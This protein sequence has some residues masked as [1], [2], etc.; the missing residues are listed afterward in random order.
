MADY[1]QICELYYVYRKPGTGTFMHYMVGGITEEHCKKDMQD[2]KALGIDAFA[3]NFNQ[4]ADWSRQTVDHL[5]NSADSYQFKLFFSFDMASGYFTDPSQYAQY[6]SQYMSRNAY[7]KIRGKPLVTTFG[8]GD[9][10]DRAW[11]NFKASLDA[12]IIL[13]LGLHSTAA[14]SSLFDQFPSLDGIFNWD[15]WPNIS[16]GKKPV[17]T[18]SDITYHRAAKKSIS[19][20]L[21]MMGLSPLQFKH[22]NPQNNWYRRGE[23]NLE[24]R[25]PQVLDLQPDLLQIQS[26][27][28]AG[29]SHYMGNSWLEPI[30]H[31][32]E[33]RAYTEGYDHRG[34]WE[35][36]PAF[37]QAWKRGDRTTA[38]MV[39]TGAGMAA[40][41]VFWHHTLLVNGRCAANKFGLERPKGVENAED[42]V[43][44]GD[45]FLLRDAGTALCVFQQRTILPSTASTIISELSPCYS[46]PEPQHSPTPN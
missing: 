10:S 17:S 40:Q 44:V 26:W 18:T 43:T 32:S 23:S 3:L 30:E 25:I 5:F 13:I 14:N 20:K 11:R 15:S 7:F 27:N 16:S 19:C 35:V 24:N 28:D 31:A 33:I 29:E 45:W 34:Y 39:P 12:E 46:P 22:I 8:G 4:F 41:G 1:Y 37:I 38:D 2:A 42:S 6:L 36:L 21:F 9:I